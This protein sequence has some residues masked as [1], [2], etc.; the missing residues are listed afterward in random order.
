[1]DDVDE[2]VGAFTSRFDK[3]ELFELL[4]KHRVPCAPVRDLDE[5][6]NDPHMHARRALEWI[7]HPDLGRIPV[8]NSPMRYEGAEPKAIVPSRRLGEDNREVYGEWLGLSRT[9]IDALAPGGGV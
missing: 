6:V 2:I 7:N 1:M 3:Q 8:P 5:V 9:Q 4:L